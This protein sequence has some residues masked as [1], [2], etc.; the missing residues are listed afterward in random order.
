M[1]KLLTAILSITVIFS[2]TVTA[3]GAQSSHTPK[4]SEQE[5]PSAFS[6]GDLGD[7]LSGFLH[8]LADAVPEVVDS[9]EAAL[10]EIVSGIQNAISE[11]TDGAQSVLDTISGQIGS[12]QDGFIQSESGDLLPGTEENS[13]DVIDESTKESLNDLIGQ[14]TAA[15]GGT[16]AS[17]EDA[18]VSEE[19]E[20]DL[21]SALTEE[22]ADDGQAMIPGGWSVN[23]E[24]TSQLSKEEE[25]LFKKAESTLAGGAYKPVAVIATQLVSGTNYAY[26]CL[27]A[28][29]AEG[30][31]A[32]WYICALY[33]DLE[34][35]VTTMSIQSI[36][37]TDIQI[38][39]NIYNPDFVGSWTPNVPE[40]DAKVLPD[41][42][43]AAFEAA[44]TD[45]V[46]VEY[47][48]IALL[49]TQVVAGLNY[50]ILCY[51]TLVTSEPVTS[52]YV[53]DIYQDLQGN[54]SI[55]DVQLFDFSEYISYGEEEPAE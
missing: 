9:V 13:Q 36:D 7:A 14:I 22:G 41:E 28:P 47:K 38:M 21:I 18:V 3:F 24:F 50:K 39:G 37:L 48:P 34:G 10:P 55:S 17:S 15:L 52:W 6:L 33:Q 23:T 51:G 44:T 1:K 46:G 49:G 16:T 43:Q 4:G 26:L 35:N 25:E 42:A 32:S 54:C 11:G 12:T 2:M 31:E 5:D 29:E 19:V 53:I 30:Q 45:Y 8:D 40:G 20:N 27:G